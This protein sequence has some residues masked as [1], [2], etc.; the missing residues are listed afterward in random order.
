MDW[1]DN[2]TGLEMVAKLDESGGEGPAVLHDGLYFAA[3][4][5]DRWPASRRQRWPQR[6]CCGAHP[7]RPGRPHGPS[8]KKKKK[9]KFCRKNT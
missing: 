7:D 9:F 6:C 2:A 3:G 5:W 4:S 8:R 1:I